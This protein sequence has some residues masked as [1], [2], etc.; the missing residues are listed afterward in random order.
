M[1]IA[2]S[3]GRCVKRARGIKIC[4]PRR[5]RREVIGSPSIFT[6]LNKEPLKFLEQKRQVGLNGFPDD[7]KIDIAVIMNDTI[8]HTDDLRER[9]GRKLGARLGS[10]SRRCFTG[11]QEASQNGVLRLGVLKKVFARLTSDVRLNSLDRLEDVEQVG[12]LSRRYRCHESI[13]VWSGGEW[14]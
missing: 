2:S 12:D 8:A 1:C 13:R 4:G 14:S 10:Q 7:L 9:D 11:H 6:A 3:A 5:Q